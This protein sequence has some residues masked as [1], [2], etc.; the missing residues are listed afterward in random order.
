MPQ[1]N[2]SDISKVLYGDLNPR[3]PDPHDEDYYIP[4]LRQ[5][6]LSE[7]I[8]TP[9]CR[10]SFT[11]PTPSTKVKYYLRRIDNWIVDVLN[12]AVTD[13]GDN[14]K[15]IILYTRLRLERA[16]QST[17]EDVQRIIKEN[18]LDI[19]Q[20]TAENADYSTN[21]PHFEGIVIF[22][23]IK[24][25][26]IYCYLEFQAQ[27]K[28]FIPQDKLLT[29]DYFYNII[30]KQPV[31]ATPYI[32]ENDPGTT[33]GTPANEPAAS[34]AKPNE[35]QEKLKSFTYESDNWNDNLIG[36]YMALSKQNG[37]IASN[38]KTT[39]FKRLFMHVDIEKPIVWLHP[40]AELAYLIKYILI[41]K[42]YIKAD[43]NMHWKIAAAAFVDKDGNHFTR[44]QLHDAK[45]PNEVAIIELQTLGDML[46]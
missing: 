32:S 30:L 40:H 10:M 37:H 46:A 22:N 31:P 29:Q 8:Y 16:A 25:A 5:M 20:L 4:E 14:D 9:L 13:S 1:D 34:Q 15:Q 23:Y 11:I 7:P 27:F 3:L 45:D 39:D 2:I 12:Q 24:I 33:H 19:R 35:A 21:L 44:Q 18:D 41:K 43:Y 28:D 42:K 6:P 36:L 17:L 38:T 26:V